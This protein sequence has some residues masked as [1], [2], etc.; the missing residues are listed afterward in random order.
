MPVQPKLENSDQHEIYPNGIRDEQYRYQETQ[1]VLAQLFR[2]GRGRFRFSGNAYKRHFYGQIDDSS[3]PV[4]YL[5]GEMARY[6]SEQ[7]RKGWEI[8]HT[9]KGLRGSV[10]K[11]W[12]FQIEQTQC[13]IEA[14]HCFGL[15]A[16]RLFVDHEKIVRARKKEFL[17]YPLFSALDD[18]GQQV[19]RVIRFLE[20]LARRGSLARNCANGMNKNL[21]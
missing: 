7:I 3:Y 13:V 21:R 16:I 4:T 8:D 20:Y 17:N 18:L 19:C 9:F 14:I 10:D 15:D 2:P 5:R 12:V 6:F 11:N 1:Y